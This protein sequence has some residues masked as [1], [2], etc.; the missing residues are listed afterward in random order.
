[1]PDAVGGCVGMQFRVIAKR[2]T[3]DVTDL[4]NGQLHRAIASG[5]DSGDLRYSGD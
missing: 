1:M 4:S 5:E 3:P 2:A